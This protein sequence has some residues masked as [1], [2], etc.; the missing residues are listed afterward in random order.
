MPGLDLDKATVRDT[1]KSF[2]LSS[3]TAELLSR[4]IALQA[5]DE[6]L[7]TPG[8]ARTFVD[9]CV[10]FIRSALR[11]SHGPFVFPEGGLDSVRECLVQQNKQDACVSTST[12]LKELLFDELGKVTGVKVFDMT[13]Q[14]EKTIGVKQV[15]ADPLLLSHDLNRVAKMGAVTG[16]VF[17]L[18]HLPSAWSKFGTKSVL[19]PASSLNRRVDVYGTIL[20]SEF[21]VCSDN[22]YQVTLSTVIED[23][24][25]EAGRRREIQ[26]LE[27]VFGLGRQ[28]EDGEKRY[29]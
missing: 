4:G 5:N 23:E 11:P 1:Y 25:H 2:G 18:K 8:S 28:L 27:E 26:R 20:D 19:V 12:T 9:A 16:I 29:I 22:I 24:N 15:I 17:N 3:D 6:N 21:G 14:S 13:N 7:D 10:S